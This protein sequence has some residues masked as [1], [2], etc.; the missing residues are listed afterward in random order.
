MSAKIDAIIAERNKLSAKLRAVNTEKF[1][2]QCRLD[3]LTHRLCKATGLYLP[4]VMLWPQTRFVGKDDS[5][6]E[7]AYPHRATYSSPTI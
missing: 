4:G 3:K 5:N 2:L 7:P 1:K 6:V